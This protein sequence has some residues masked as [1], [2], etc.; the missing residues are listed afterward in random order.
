MYSDDGE[1]VISI[2]EYLFFLM[3]FVVGVLEYKCG[4]DVYY[5]DYL[6][7]LFGFVVGY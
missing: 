3:F 7:Y 1:F 4:N 6:L 5:V 2:I